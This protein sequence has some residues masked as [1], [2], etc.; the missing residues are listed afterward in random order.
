MSF[1]ESDSPVSLE[2]LQHPVVRRARRR[3]RRSSTALINTLVV[4]VGSTLVV[5]GAR[6]AARHR[7][8]SPCPLAAARRAVHG[9][10]G[11]CPT[12]SWP[13]ACWRFYTTVG[14]DPR[15]ALGA[16]VAHRVRHRLRGRG[17]PG[18]TRP[19][20]PVPRGGVPRPRGASQ[21]TTFFR[22][23]IPSVWPAIIA[24]GAARVH[25]VARRV[26]HRLLHRRAATPTLPIV[27]YSMV[28]FGVTPEVNALAAV[29]LLVS[30]VTVLAGPAPDRGGRR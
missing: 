8:P 20:R 2:R 27:I 9:S 12:S 1:N 10:G 13:S 18:A 23:T 26:R 22:I 3:T 30:F 15:A 16:A 29:L 4:A 19:R 7:P 14:P 17:R 24:G 6:H 28:R 25:A 11:R 5:G 21:L